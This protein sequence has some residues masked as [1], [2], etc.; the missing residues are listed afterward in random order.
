MGEIAKRDA[1]DIQIGGLLITKTGIRRLGRFSETDWKNCAAMLDQFNQGVNWCVGDL[2]LLGEPEFGEDK[3]I[4]WIDEMVPSMGPQEKYHCQHVSNSFPYSNRLESLT[5]THH[6]VLAYHNNARERFQL[7]EQAEKQKLSTGDLR[8]RLRAHKLAATAAANPLP[9][10]KYRVIYADP[11]WKYADEL[12]EGYGAAEHHYPT[13]TIAELAA[14]PIKDLALPDAV[15]FMWVTSPLLEECF[16]VIK[17]WG[18]Q[19]KS[20]FVWD[21]VKHNFGH[22]NSVRH[23]LLLI[24]TR[25]SCTPDSGELHDSVVSVERNDTHSSKP[26]EFRRLID[27]LYTDGQRIEL[28]SRTKAKGW[29]VWGNE[30]HKGAA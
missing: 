21:K 2:M 10:D 17:G 29:H 3:V 1:R 11:P 20:M 19:Y 5:W 14:L 18:F 22:Y 24:C 9:K 13:M 4:Q 8:K 28:F 16:E 12:I 25:G 23:E 26:E 27:S 6:F 30:A 7:L 15:L